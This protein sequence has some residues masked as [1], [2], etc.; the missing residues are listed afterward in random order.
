M[1]RPCR[2][3]FLSEELLRLWVFFLVLLLLSHTP[4]QLAN[5]YHTLRTGDNEGGSVE[6]G[7]D[8]VPIA[9]EV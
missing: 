9:L 8:G 2:S 6:E 3:V 5:N 4:R 1:A 7:E